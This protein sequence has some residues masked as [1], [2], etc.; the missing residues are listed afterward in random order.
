MDIRV[1]TAALLFA[2]TS[3]SAAVYQCNVGGQKVFS[4]RPCATDAKEIEVK[5]APKVGGSLVTDAD[6]SLL[7]TFDND[8]AVKRID[9][10]IEERQERVSTLRRQMDSAL[11]EWQ[12]QKSLANNNLAGATWEAA[13]AQEADVLRQRYQSQIDEEL[14][15]IERLRTQRDQL[16][17]SR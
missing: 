12:K 17:S 16:S 9:R 11:L 15:E 6:R 2:S 13:L 1:F 8:R 10:S 7:Q 14:R 4:D 5:A 3:A